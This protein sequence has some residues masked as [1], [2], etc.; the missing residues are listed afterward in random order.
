M[1]TSGG[2][3]RLLYDSV[4][5]PL[6]PTGPQDEYGIS[7]PHT[8]AGSNSDSRP[9][10]FTDA[11]NPRSESE[12]EQR[13]SDGT[14]M[15]S[16][17]GTHTELPNRYRRSEYRQPAVDES[18]TMITARSVINRSTEIPG[19]SLYTYNYNVHNCI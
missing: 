15:D 2:I 12:D 6:L 1:A 7:S 18:G 3:P 9:R 13:A 8:S 5:E 19:I 17:G 10:H 4:H 11:L 16:R 14:Q